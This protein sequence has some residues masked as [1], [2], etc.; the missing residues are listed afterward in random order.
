MRGPSLKKKSRAGFTFLEIISV[1]VIIAI[2]ATF[3]VTNYQK[4]IY[5]SRKKVAQRNKEAIEKA[6]KIYYIKF[7]SYPTILSNEEEINETLNIN[8]KDNYFNYATNEGNVMVT[9]NQGN[10]IVFEED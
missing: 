2:L 7:N 3:A 9:D 4:A 10:P 8:I 1:V 6:L 5:E